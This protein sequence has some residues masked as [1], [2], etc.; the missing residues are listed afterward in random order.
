MSLLE[1]AIWLPRRTEVGEDEA[2]DWASLEASETNGE[3][4]MSAEEI[5]AAIA[6]ATAAAE[7]AEHS[8]VF[9]TPASIGLTEMPTVEELDAL[10]APESLRL[11]GA[12][13]ALSYLTDDMLTAVICE[14]SCRLS[15]E[16]KGR[17]AQQMLQ[18]LGNKVAA[19]KAR[20]DEAARIAEAERKDQRA[21]ECHLV[22]ALGEFVNFGIRK[23]G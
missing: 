13:V 17:V 9:V 20:A 14:S 8:G 7:F 10:P 21:T 15:D 3:N 18:M 19:K 16:N 12:R 11:S 22:F 23:V 1:P 4:I 5:E 6:E 2:G